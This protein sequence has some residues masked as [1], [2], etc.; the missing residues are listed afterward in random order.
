MKRY[1]QIIK[2]LKRE[3]I[4][5]IGKKTIN[6]ELKNLAE[7]QTWKI[8]PKPEK[9]NLLDSKWVFTKKN[10]EGK[11]ICKARLVVRGFQQK[12]H[13]E[14]TYSPVLKL[15]TL[16]ILL[17]IASCRK[18]HIHQMDVKGAFLYGK[19]NED[20]YLLPP[21]GIEVPKGRVLKLVKS[22]YGLKKSPK[23]WYEKFNST[24]TEYGFRRSENDYCL[25]IMKNMYL[26][27]YVDD[28]LIL[29]SSLQEIKNLKEFLSTQFKMKDMGCENLM[30]LGISINKQSGK[31]LI[32]QR[33]YL[34]SILKKFN[35]ENCKGS[36]TPMDVNIKLNEDSIIDMKYEMQCRSL[37]GSLMVCMQQ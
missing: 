18:Y 32:N 22:L 2:R 31:I 29:G 28:L 10:V 26:L 17:S 23:Y 1:R 13:L 14:D 35:M 20:V 33:K 27:L 25:F 37:I 24:I 7:N 34:Q 16:R 8:V 4:N 11:E 15:Q 19:M 21:E 12:E 6:E 30:Y 36:N 5:K 9:E 3:R